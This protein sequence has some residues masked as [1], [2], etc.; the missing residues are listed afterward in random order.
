[1]FQKLF[2]DRNEG[3]TQAFPPVYLKQV[4]QPAWAIDQWRTCKSKREEFEFLI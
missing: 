1:M 4:G 2:P 3:K